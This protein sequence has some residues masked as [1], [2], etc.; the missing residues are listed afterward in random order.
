MWVRVITPTIP[1]DPGLLDLALERHPRA[2]RYS[3]PIRP[4]AALKEVGVP[5]ICKVHG[6]ARSFRVV[7]RRRRRNR[8]GHG[9]G[10]ARRVVRSTMP[11]KP[12]VSEAAEAWDRTNNGTGIA[13]ELKKVRDGRTACPPPSAPATATCDG[14]ETHMGS[15]H[16][17]LKP[18]GH[19]QGLS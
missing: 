2:H 11:F 10:P 18:E 1:E 3:S 15:E 9:S 14:L 6:L 5:L 4:C 19:L 8:A 13:E 12:A 16:R 17:W 7:D